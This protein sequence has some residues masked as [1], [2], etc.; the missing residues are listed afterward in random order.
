MPA[1]VQFNLLNLMCVQIEIDIDNAFGIKI[2]L[3]VV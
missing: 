1:Y 3:V 2:K